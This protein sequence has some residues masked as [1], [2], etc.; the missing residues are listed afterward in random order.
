[1]R[2]KPFKIFQVI[3]VS[4]GI[5]AEGARHAVVF[6]RFCMVAQLIVADA[7]LDTWQVAVSVLRD[8]SAAFVVAGNGAGRCPQKRF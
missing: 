2:G 6:F 4:R 1:M 5:R 8:E 3:S 7:E